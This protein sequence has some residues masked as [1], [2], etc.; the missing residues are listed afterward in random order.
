MSA[1]TLQDSHYTV[2]NIP[3]KVGYI[4]VYFNE[5]I[6]KNHS[7]REEIIP[8]IDIFNDLESF[9][10]IKQ[11][12]QRFGYLNKELAFTKQE[13]LFIKNNPVIRFSENDWPPFAMVGGN[14]FEGILNEYIKIL[15]NKTTI[16]FSYVK[17]K[18]WADVLSK[19]KNNKIDFI[20][21]VPNIKKIQDMGL[22]SNSFMEFNLAIIMNENETFINGLEGLNGKI[23]ALPK[24]FMP[25]KLIRSKYPK[26]KVIDTETDK[27]ALTLVSEGKADAFVSTSASASFN[28]RNHYQNLKI[29]GLSKE[30]HKH[31]MLT[32]KHIPS[33]YL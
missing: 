21:S 32:K 20:P 19:F 30:K 16:H 11:I 22:V 5:E 28:I 18:S 33:F 1:Y 15:E 27:E 26:I 23:V 29:V 14:K 12:Y 7:R 8:N 24:Y 3:V 17:T 6:L 10:Y 31:Y 9:S 2:S 13:Q 25:N 4:K